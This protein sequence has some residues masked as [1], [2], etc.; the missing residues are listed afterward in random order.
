M[1]LSLS[2]K[3]KRQSCV[4]LT[5]SLEEHEFAIFGCFRMMICSISIGSERLIR[6]GIKSRGA[7]DELH[8]GMMQ[9]QGR[10]FEF[11]HLFV[12]V[13]F[14]MCSK[15]T[16]RVASDFS[17]YRTKANDNFRTG[18]TSR[19]KRY[20][21]QVVFDTNTINIRRKI[22]MAFLGVEVASFTTFCIRWKLELCENKQYREKPKSACP[23]DILVC[24]FESMSHV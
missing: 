19:G 23:F 3:K 6:R 20:L 11:T 7:S 18:S 17:K 15:N 22:L 2:F 24:V 9:Q 8:C 13:S 16:K 10:T 5:K 14:L 21:A 12:P 4:T 1:S